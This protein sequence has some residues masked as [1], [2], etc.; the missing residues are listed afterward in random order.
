MQTDVC[1][2][3]GTSGAEHAQMWT[4]P[5]RSWPGR[6]RSGSRAL[7]DALQHPILVRGRRRDTCHASR[8][9]PAAVRGCALQPRSDMPMQ[10]RAGLLRKRRR[11]LSGRSRAACAE[12]A[13]PLRAASA[14]S[15]CRARP[16]AV[17]QRTPSAALS[18]ASQDSAPLRPLGS[19]RHPRRLRR[20]GVQERR[21]NSR[22]RHERYRHKV[23]RR[24]GRHERHERR[25][26]HR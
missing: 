4:N 3:R 7:A 6:N 8:S 2:N 16:Q 25:H 24:H 26:G 11:A 1:P 15:S 23:H 17:C 13:V 19:D 12:Q 9:L 22:R 14:R 18:M 5:G 10:L 21:R 20:Q